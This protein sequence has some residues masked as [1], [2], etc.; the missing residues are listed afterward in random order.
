MEEEKYLRI[1]DMPSKRPGRSLS[2]WGRKRKSTQQDL[3]EY[4]EHLHILFSSPSLCIQDILYKELKI[5]NEIR[6]ILQNRARLKLDLI[7]HQAK[8]NHEVLIPN[9]TTDTRKCRCGGAL[10]QVPKNKLY[11]GDKTLEIVCDICERVVNEDYVLHC[12]NDRNELHPHGFDVCLQCAEASKIPISITFNEFINIKGPMLTQYKFHTAYV[13][14]RSSSAYLNSI[15]SA[16]HW[17]LKL[18]GVLYF[19]TNYTR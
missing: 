10:Q 16:N 9:C 13:V 2:Q 11:G 14:Q 7:F 5:D 12:V 18:E 17:V 1:P 15:F 8:Y 3:M 19:V 6:K 4:A